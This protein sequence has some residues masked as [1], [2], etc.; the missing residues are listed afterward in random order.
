MAG[1]GWVGGFCGLCRDGGAFGGGT[2][3]SVTEV[4]SGIYTVDFGAGD[5]NGNV[6]LLRCTA[7]ACDD[8]FERIVTQP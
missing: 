1:A 6:I 5:L 3:A 8:A 7:T 2:L 4:G